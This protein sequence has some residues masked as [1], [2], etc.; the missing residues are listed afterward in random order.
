MSYQ[1]VDEK[2]A[3][4]ATVEANAAGRHI[5]SVSCHTAFQAGQ[6]SQIRI[7]QLHIDLQSSS[8]ILAVNIPTSFG[9]LASH[10][11]SSQHANECCIVALTRYHYYNG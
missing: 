4:F 10:M 1:S 11:Q 9:Q 7:S 2:V 5:W 3:P 8:L 6:R